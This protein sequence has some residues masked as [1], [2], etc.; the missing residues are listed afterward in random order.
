M[1][2]LQRFWQWLT[3]FRNYLK[4]RSLQS[5]L[6]G[7]RRFPENFPLDD[8]LWENSSPKNSAILLEVVNSSPQY[9]HR[10]EKQFVGNIDYSFETF[11]LDIFATEIKCSHQNILAKYYPIR[12]IL[13]AKRSMFRQSILRRRKFQQRISVR[14]IFFPTKN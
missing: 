7:I 11:S 8:F 9:I 14:W 12:K 6:T 2:M 10:I 13:R 3:M 4:A 5:F 1:K